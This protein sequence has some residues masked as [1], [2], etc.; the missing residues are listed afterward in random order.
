MYPAVEKEKW[1]SQGGKKKRMQ[2]DFLEGRWVLKKAAGEGA[3]L[4]QT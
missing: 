2:G 4:Q 3:L 1:G